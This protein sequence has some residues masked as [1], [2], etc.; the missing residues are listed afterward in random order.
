MSNLSNETIPLLIK[1]V[2][3]K[4]VRGIKYLI[5][6]KDI[7]IN[8]EDDY[9]WT[10]L[11]FAFSLKYRCI[12]AAKLLLKH[13]DIDVNKDI[14]IKG[15]KLIHTLCRGGR[16]NDLKLLMTHYSLNINAVNAKGFTPLHIAIQKGHGDIIR[17]LLSDPRIDTEYFNNSKP[18]II[19]T[20]LYLACAH[21]D[22]ESIKI[23]VN[24]D[25]INVNV[26]KGV[27]DN[28]L[29]RTIADGYCDIM[30][31]FLSLKEMDRFQLLFYDCTLLMSACECDDF[32]MS[33]LLVEK[34][35]V[36][37]INQRNIEGSTAL[38]YA[39]HVGNK[40]IVLMLLRMGADKNIINYKQRSA[41]KIATM[42]GNQDCIDLLNGTKKYTLYPTCQNKTCE[43]IGHYLCSGCY[44]KNY[45]CK[46]C[47]IEDWK[48]PAGEGG[49]KKWCKQKQ[50]RNRR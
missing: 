1:L 11:C 26:Y 5:K 36:S 39:S 15:G 32:P 17:L 30:K 25:R 24:D 19:C 42:R 21:K 47:Q 16:I 8:E 12:P 9:G 44:E 22:L 31:H 49:H 29:Y 28:H 18:P 6:K 7:N 41:L 46:D 20:P 50:K 23:L 13:P 43:Y 14:S 27:Y 37:Y 2:F 10:A 45:C 34:V 4:R 48:R 38:M 35:G 3:L 40:D 33:I